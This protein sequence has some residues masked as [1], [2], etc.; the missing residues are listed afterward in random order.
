MLAGLIQREP[1]AW[2]IRQMA[3][4]AALQAGLFEV[5]PAQ[6]DTALSM[7]PEAETA[8]IA[9]FRSAVANGNNTCISP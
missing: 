5:A 1:N 3:A 4:E 9:A 2:S 6:A 7:A 8:G